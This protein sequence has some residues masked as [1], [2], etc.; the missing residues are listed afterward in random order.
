MVMLYDLVGSGQ[1][2]HAVLFDYGQRHVQELI[3]AKCHCHRL[4]VLFTTIE[5]SRLHGSQLTYDKGGVVVPNRNAIFLS[6]AANLAESLG[7]ERITYACN[8]DDF[9]VFPDCRAHFILA[10]NRMLESAGLKVRVSAPYMNKPKW[11][12]L[13][14]GQE[15]GVALHETWSCY[16]GGLKPCGKCLACKTRRKAE[17]CV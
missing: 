1:K 6:L 12:I 2:V 15:M 9:K 16:K 11:K 14:L 4:K 8:E 7:C 17:K 5:V 10:F 3:W 13:A